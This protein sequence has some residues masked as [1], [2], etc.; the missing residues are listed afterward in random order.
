ML[1]QGKQS[2][3]KGELLDGTEIKDI[4]MISTK[5]ICQEGKKNETNNETK[6]RNG[7]LGFSVAVGEYIW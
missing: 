7:P 1:F 6:A 3:P 5:Y 4:I 2:W